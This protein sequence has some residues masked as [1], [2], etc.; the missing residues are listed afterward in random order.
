MEINRGTIVVINGE[1]G[2]RFGL[3]LYPARPDNNPNRLRLFVVHT[4]NGNLHFEEKEMLPVIQLKVAPEP[5]LSAGPIYV[6]DDLEE[7]SL[8]D[9]LRQA[10]PDIVLSLFTAVNDL[11]NSF[12]KTGKVIRVSKDSLRNWKWMKLPQLPVQNTHH[13]S[14]MDLGS[15]EQRLVADI[16]RD[17]KQERFVGLYKKKNFCAA[18][19][20]DMKI[21]EKKAEEIIKSLLRN[22]IIREED[23][24]LIPLTPLLECAT[25]HEVIAPRESWWSY[26]YT[27]HDV[28]IVL[29]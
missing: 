10:M 6:P 26:T 14:T 16:L 3:V 17:W 7:V 19:A 18:I 29:T 23:G 22:G 11:R 9:V 8:E 1:G 28:N 24:Y 21:S 2:N 20:E 12:N 4:T 27:Y 15:N 25:P 13:L 5:G